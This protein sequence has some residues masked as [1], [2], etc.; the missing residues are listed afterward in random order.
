MSVDS[1]E[2]EMIINE[3]DGLPNMHPNYTDLQLNEHTSQHEDRSYEDLISDE[4]LPTSIIVTNL[5][6]ALFKNDELKVRSKIILEAY[7]KNISNFYNRAVFLFYF[8]QSIH[9]HIHV[10]ISLQNKGSNCHL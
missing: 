4:D 6:N 8:Q 9:M 2:G 10:G 5:D 7:N 1:E 3:M